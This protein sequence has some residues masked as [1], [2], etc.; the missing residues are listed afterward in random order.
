MITITTLVTT[1]A[2]VLATALFVIFRNVF[3]NV[4]VDLNVGAQLGTKMFAFVW[5]A[6]GCELLGMVLQW[7]MCCCSCCGRR[8]SG[9][10]KKDH[11]IGGEDEKEGSDA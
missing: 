11:G 2:A 6:V 3:A 4:S 8:K 7:G 9:W 5:V 10:E 1:I